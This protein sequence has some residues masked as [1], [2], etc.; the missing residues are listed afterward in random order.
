MDPNN[1]DDGSKRSRLAPS[2]T[3][4]TFIDDRL[5]NPNHHSPI[6]RPPATQSTPNEA[7]YDSESSCTQRLFTQPQQP[8]HDLPIHELF[9]T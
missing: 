2:S 7:D 5:T 1:R 8:P 6:A 3:T 9:F 4:K